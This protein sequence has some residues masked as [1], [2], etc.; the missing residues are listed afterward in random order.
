MYL[1]HLC[2]RSMVKS[3]F[4]K[5]KMTNHTLIHTALMFQFMIKLFKQTLGKV[6][7]RIWKYRLAEKQTLKKISR[8]RHRNFSL[9]TIQYLLINQRLSKLV[10][11]SIHQD[12][13][14]K[15]KYRERWLSHHLK[16]ILGLVLKSYLKE[17]T[18]LY[19]QKWK[20]QLTQSVGINL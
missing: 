16:A 9:I 17:I 8:C 20:L 2:L 3:L 12:K 6:R 4:I 13:K 11:K 1:A 14:L 15:F 10:G 7:L 5:I 18:K 19:R